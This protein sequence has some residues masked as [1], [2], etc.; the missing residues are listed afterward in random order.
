[1]GDEWGQGY[2]RRA[3]IW[4]GLGDHCA[5]PERLI[6]VQASGG[7]R[8]SPLAK[9]WLPGM[10]ELQAVNADKDVLYDQTT[11]QR[12]RSL[13]AQFQL[14]E[15]TGKGLTG[16]L[17]YISQSPYRVPDQLLGTPAGERAQKAIARLDALGV[18]RDEWKR[19]ARTSEGVKTTLAALGDDESA[20]LI[21]HA[22]V[23]AAVNLHVLLGFPIPDALPTRDVVQRWLAGGTWAG[24]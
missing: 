24:A 13:V 3:E 14:A 22:Y 18:S 11:A 19:L 21:W 2:A 9:P 10:S 6:V 17:V 12:R 5:P 1:M 4:P 8:F 7:K 23:L 15:K 16:A 20:L